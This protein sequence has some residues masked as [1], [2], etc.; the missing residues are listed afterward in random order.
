MHQR[1]IW[2]YS[3]NKQR[4]E[5][6]KYNVTTAQC[7]GMVEIRGCDEQEDSTS[8]IPEHKSIE[9]SGTEWVNYL[10]KI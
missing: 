10:S 2:F 3:W 1:L 5:D 4:K 6:D 9:T 7:E 8:T